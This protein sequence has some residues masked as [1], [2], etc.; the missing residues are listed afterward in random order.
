MRKVEAA[1]LKLMR[2]LEVSDEYAKQEN[3]GPLPSVWQLQNSHIRD[4]AREALAA[5]AATPL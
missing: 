4:R 5:I 1:L 3:S 2:Q